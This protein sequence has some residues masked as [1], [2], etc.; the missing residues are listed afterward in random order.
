MPEL[1]EVETI[2]RQ[3]EPLIVGKRISSIEAL[4]LGSF[5]ADSGSLIGK[6][7]I[8][9]G[10]KGKVLILS[11]KGDCQLF[12]HLKMSGQLEYKAEGRRPKDE[13]KKMTL[14]FC[15]GESMLW[16]RG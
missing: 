2:R 16:I 5:R 8:A 10:R 4:N 3:L 7:V 6:T 12:I 9:V 1:P 14:Q 13:G 15:Q 11:L